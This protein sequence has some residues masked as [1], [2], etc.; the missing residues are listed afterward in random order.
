MEIQQNM[1]TSS[2]NMVVF[3]N[4]LNQHMGFPTLADPNSNAGLT[5]NGFR[6]W[7]WRIT[8]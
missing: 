6:N 1:G 4:R 3:L 5:N 8:Q 7:G 2:E